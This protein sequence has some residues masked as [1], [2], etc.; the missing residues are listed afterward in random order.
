MK[1][2]F[3]IGDFPTFCH[4]KIN[5]AEGDEHAERIIDKM[6]AKKILSEIHLLLQN[7]KPAY[8][9]LKSIVFGTALVFG[10]AIGMAY[11][12]VDEAVFLNLSVI[13]GNSICC[14]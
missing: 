13:T 11:H 4:T 10:I 6:S 12:G 5:I 7:K 14:L 2:H 9:E 3:S 8:R 1:V